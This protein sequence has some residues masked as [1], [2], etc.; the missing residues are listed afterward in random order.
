MD[1]LQAFHTKRVDALQAECDQHMATINGKSVEIERLLDRRRMDEDLRNAAHQDAI[2]NLI[3]RHRQEL[4]LVRSEMERKMEGIP[5][6]TPLKTEPKDQLCKNCIEIS[7][8]KQKLEQV[9]SKQYTFRWIARVLLTHFSGFR[10]RKILRC[11]KMQLIAKLWTC[12]R[13]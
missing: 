8:F 9:N 5:S 4:E 3:E 7:N 2:L 1:E 11:G 6:L 10:R 12:I 13:S